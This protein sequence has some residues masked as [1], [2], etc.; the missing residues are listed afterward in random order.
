MSF[1]FEMSLEDV[2]GL[3]DLA[4]LLIEHEINP[5]IEAL[6]SRIKEQLATMSDDEVW[7]LPEGFVPVPSRANVGK[8]RTWPNRDHSQTR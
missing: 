8:S 2:S 6:E 1:T 7:A 5:C 4:S 3:R